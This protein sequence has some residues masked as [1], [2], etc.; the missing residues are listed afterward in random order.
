[1]ADS[2]LFQVPIL[3]LAIRAYGAYSVKR[4]TAD[5]SAIRSAVRQ[6]QEDWAIGIYLQ[7][8]RSHDARIVS[9]KLGAALIAAKAQVPLLPVS[10][11]GTDKV[12]PKGCW[13]P[14]SYPVTVRIG[15]IVPPPVGTSKVELKTVTQRC[16]NDIHAL[17]DL[18][19]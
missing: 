8:G 1:M 5:R 3:G 14:R 2:S 11:W 19:R 15:K 4:G 9:P 16:M 6:L 7:G 13:L 10:L 18:R 12:L 17:Y